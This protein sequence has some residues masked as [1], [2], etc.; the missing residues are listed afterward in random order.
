MKTW[1]RSCLLLLLVVSG[2]VGEKY[3]YDVVKKHGK[4]F[5]V[6]DVPTPK[7]VKH[8]AKVKKRKAALRKK[9][10]NRARKRKLE[11]ERKA[12]ELKASVAASQAAQNKQASPAPVPTS[13]QNS[14]ANLPEGKRKLFLEDA[15]N[16]VKEIAR[17][18]AGKGAIYGAGAGAG[19]G[20]GRRV[21]LGTKKAK[22]LQLIDEYELMTKAAQMIDKSCYQVFYALKLAYT[23]LESVGDGI[24]LN[25]MRKEDAIKELLDSMVI[26]DVLFG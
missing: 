11:N 12:A 21:A 8:K 18:P 10:K 9:K 14:M 13:P 17:G 5:M 7:S 20:L 23:K 19:I 26:G 6:V 16:K 3:E 25:L 2:I 24:P 1:L 4:N 22:F 15:F